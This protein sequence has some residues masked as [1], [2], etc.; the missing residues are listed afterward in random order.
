L[1]TDYI[2]LVVA[3]DNDQGFEITEE[4]AGWF[5]FLDRSKREFPKID[6]LGK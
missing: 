3:S 2:C 1:T 5:Q 6:S 4:H